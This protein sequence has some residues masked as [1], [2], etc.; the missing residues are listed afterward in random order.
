MPVCTHDPK[1]A[2]TVGE[3]NAY[4]Q[5]VLREGIPFPVWVQGA[6]TRIST[7]NNSIYCSLKDEKGN[8]LK[9]V[10][11]GGES[12]FRKLELDEGKQVMALGSIDLYAYSGQYQLNVQKV[13]PLNTI[14][15]LEQ[16]RREIMEKLAKEGLFEAARKK[17]VPQYPVCV[18]VIT[19]LDH[20]KAA[21]H[22]FMDT[23]YKNA[24]G[25][26]LRL[27]GS[28]M[29]GAGTAANIV[30]IIEFLNASAACDVIVITRGG[31]S[32]EDLWE[33][34]DEAL[35]RA[36]AES[37]IPVVSAV[38]HAIDRP[39]CDYVA[40]CAAITPTD[41]A[42]AVTRGWLQL[43]RALREA[44]SRM[45][46]CVRL[47]LANYRVRT[48]RVSDCACLAHPRLFYSQY[49][50]RLDQLSM[51]IASS[52][53]QISRGKHE[54][55]LSLEP[56]LNAS[57]RN[58]LSHFRSQLHASAMV[59]ASLDPK[60]VLKRGYA[61]VM[62]GAGHAVRAPG[63]VAPGQRL[64]AMLSEGTINVQ[65]LKEKEKVGRERK[66]RPEGSGL[67]PG[68]EL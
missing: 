30:K 12:V 56:R 43:P 25:L 32:A 24:P 52:L 35:A 40:D 53:P 36:V 15:E 16:R 57:M 68:M 26:H 37:E 10:Y 48:G 28:K 65:V 46:A 13:I 5:A 29:Q 66:R 11:F 33:F 62:D 4:A 7:H 34:N 3:L 54:R 21:V 23:V 47:L 39:V 60:A 42:N 45:Q 49:R 58:E 67:L 38:G 17:T 27:V 19:S 1:V 14:G 51:R 64:S 20:G 41:A 6:L 22:D 18:G 55:L 8:Q 44:D 59:L 9:I 61:I 50:Q 2:W 31:G 63:E